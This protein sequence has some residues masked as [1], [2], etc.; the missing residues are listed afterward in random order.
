MKK[1]RITFK[2]RDVR[3]YQE[4]NDKVIDIEVQDI[5]GNIVDIENTE[6]DTEVQFEDC[7]WIEYT[8]EDMTEQQ[9]G[10][11]LEKVEEFIEVKSIV[12]ELVEL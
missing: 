7:Y 2:L 5:V 1:L 6:S 12:L 3:E 8:V 9:K 4:Q 10:N 11:I